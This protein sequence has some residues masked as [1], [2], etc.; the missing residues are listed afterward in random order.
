[1]NNLVS[2]FSRLVLAGALLGL[3]FSPKAQ[4][5]NEPLEPEIAFALSAKLTDQPAQLS[6]R[7]KSV[8]GYYLYRPKIS[9]VSDSPILN[10][11]RGVYPQGIA[12]RDEYFGET[13]IYRG[14]TEIRYPLAQ[15]QGSLTFTVKSQGCADIGIC[16][17][18][19]EQNFNIVSETGW[20]SWKPI[21][22]ALGGAL[23]PFSSAKSPSASSSFA[24]ENPR[25]AATIHA[26]SPPAMREQSDVEKIAF[27]IGER[28]LMLSLLI[29]WGMG[30]ALSLTPCN[31]PMVPILGALLTGSLRLK[32]HD[33]VAVH[34]QAL[35]QVKGSP[36]RGLAL[37]ASFVL[38][39]SLTYALVGALAGLSGELFS[40]S[41]QTPA[42]QIGAAILVLVFAGGCFGWYTI[43][44]PNRVQSW[45]RGTADKPKQ[46][47]IVGLI[48]SGAVSALIVGPCIAAPLAGALLYIGQQSDA[49][50]GALLLFALAW[51]QGVPLLLFGFSA[52]RFMPKM[53][54]W[55]SAV[56]R[57]F[58][59]LLIALALWFVQPTLS[60]EIFMVALGAWLIVSALFLGA[61][62]THHENIHPLRRLGK[63]LGIILLIYGV[64]IFVGYF[65]GSRSIAQP[66]ERFTPS[67]QKSLLGAL[68]WQAVDSP[69]GLQRA[70]ALA[71]DQPVI[72][73]FYADWCVT[74]HEMESQTLRDQA[75]IDAL[76]SFVLLRADVT[77]HSPEHRQ[78]LQQFGLFGPPAML[79]FNRGNEKRAARLIGFEEAPDFVLRLTQAR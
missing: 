20:Q 62:Q 30:L 74:C 40:Q 76:Q 59:F 71:G 22:T 61:L 23:S 77:A 56:N 2:L 8:E 48:F 9:V 49:F 7:F 4:A 44:I 35:H 70:L 16:Y 19:Q 45:L 65:S 13:E 58:G 75:V 73:D 21:K 3:S 6:L 5:P 43:Q 11:A 46:G 57:L 27:A 26:D 55:M 37:S 33:H 53:G 10:S 47:S 60:R 42:F 15:A 14:E 66:L 63:A 38:G 72:L 32:A 52:D 18:P 67:P 39:M 1:M 31:L 68:N 51:G 50:G 79:F 78:L 34:P 29:F 36:W 41:L 64:A 17:P 69:E 12:H 54:A 24:P 28:G 25:D